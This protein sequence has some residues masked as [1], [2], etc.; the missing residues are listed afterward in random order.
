MKMVRKYKLTQRETDEMLEALDDYIWI[1]IDAKKGV[2]SAGDEYVADL[3]DELLMNRS[4][5][6]DIYGLGLNLKTGEIDYLPA[7]NRRNPNTDNGELCANE[8]LRLETLTR[9]FFEY[10]PCYRAERCAPR[11]RK[12]A[13]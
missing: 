8:K 11:Y 7:I 1:A 6:G 5:I 3:R 12:Y 10:I 2:I 4:Q 9:Y 13:F